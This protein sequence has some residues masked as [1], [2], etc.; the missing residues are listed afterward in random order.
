MGKFNTTDKRAPRAGG[1]IKTAQTPTALTYNGA[2]GYEYDTLSQLYLLAVNNMVGEDTFYE[3]AETRDNRYE[4][5]IV[6]AVAEGHIEW[7]T[8]FFPWLRNSANMR[9]ASMIGGIEA[10]RAM[11]DRKI[12]GGRAL[13]NSVL[14]RADEPGEALAYFVSNYGRSIPKPIKRAVADACARLYT[15]RNTIKYD[16][17]SHGFRFGDVLELCHAAPAPVQVPGGPRQEA[18]ADPAAPFADHARRSHG[19]VA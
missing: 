10:A 19:A 6:R 1:P 4:S 18:S 12:P 15:Q 17:A 5:L 11:V 14:V 8:R 3:S 9:T 7:L 16:T 2:A 13:V